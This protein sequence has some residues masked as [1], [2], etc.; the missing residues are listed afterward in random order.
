MRYEDISPEQAMKLAIE[1]S[2]DGCWESQ[3]QIPW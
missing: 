1:T 3:K 2:V